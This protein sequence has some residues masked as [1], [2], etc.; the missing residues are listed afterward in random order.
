MKARIT[1]LM[2]AAALALGALSTAHAVEVQGAKLEDTATV[3]GKNLV[4]NGAGARIKAVFKVYAIGLYL[5]EKKTTTADIL[6]LN[7][8]KRFKIVFLRDLSSEEFGSAFLAGINKNLEKDEKTKFVNQITKFGDLFTEFEGVKK[9]E[10]IIGDY[11]PAVGTTITL[12]GKQL[13]S[14]L[15]DIGFYNA[16]LRIWIGANPA[17][18]MLK[19]LLLGDKP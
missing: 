6:A 19:P 9:G 8:P 5:T 3:A 10:V 18:N 1:A 7:G 15:P 4:L 11:N 13:G 14:P 12:N 2:T 16:I 17:D